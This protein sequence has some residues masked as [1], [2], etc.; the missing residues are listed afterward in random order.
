VTANLPA[1]QRPEASAK[2]AT[3]LAEIDAQYD[4]HVAALREHAVLVQ[5]AVGNDADELAQRAEPDP[6]RL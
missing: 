1:T 4:A 2:A 6:S 5:A 3:H